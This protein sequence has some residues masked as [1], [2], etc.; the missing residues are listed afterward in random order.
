[1]MACWTCLCSS[2]CLLFLGGHG[3]DG[4]N[5]VYAAGTKMLP[6]TETHCSNGANRFLGRRSIKGQQRRRLIFFGG[7]R[8]Q[9]GI[10]G[11]NGLDAAGTK[12]LPVT[13]T[14]PAMAQIDFLGRQ[15]YYFMGCGIEATNGAGWLFF[16]GTQRQ[17]RQDCQRRWKRRTKPPMPQVDRF[18]KNAAS[19]PV[20]SQV[21]CFL[22]D[23][24]SKQATLTMPLETWH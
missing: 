10:D 16:F 12:M 7:I 14:L 5:G 24:A 2:T 21:N 13:E 17:R 3:I 4:N 11:N 23:V 1:M 15:V 9:W 19:R 8:R 6:V 20:A 22:E 18:L